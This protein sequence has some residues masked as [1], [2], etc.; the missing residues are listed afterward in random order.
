MKAKFLSAM[1]SIALAGCVVAPRVRPANRV[2]LYRIQQKVDAMQ[3]AAAG[4]VFQGTKKTKD[5]P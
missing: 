4:I 5:T 2:E 3:A 1:I